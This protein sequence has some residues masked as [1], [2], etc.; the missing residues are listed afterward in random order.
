MCSS[1]VAKLRAPQGFS[2]TTELELESSSSVSRHLRWLVVQRGLNTLL[3]R[4]LSDH[5]DHTSGLG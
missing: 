5:E 1:L 3:H 2:E 4:P